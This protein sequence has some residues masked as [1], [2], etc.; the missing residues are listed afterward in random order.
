MGHQHSTP[1][2][3]VPGMYS[4]PP[5][6]TAPYYG[7]SGFSGFYPSVPAPHAGPSTSTGSNGSAGPIPGSAGNQGAWSDEET[8][9]LKKLAE[10][11]R[12]ANGDIAWDALCEKW[13]NSRTR[14][15]FNRVRLR[16]LA[17]DFESGTKYSSKRLRL[18]SK[19]HLRGGQSVGVIQR[20]N[21]LPIAQ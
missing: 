13:G 16:V 9:K 19:N 15:C 12:N 7:Y 18:V 14:C 2:P 3:F 17:D 10:E 1:Q 6:P 5:Y 8:E 11:H 20:V 21:H 4:A